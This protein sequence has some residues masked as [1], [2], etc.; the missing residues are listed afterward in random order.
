MAAGLGIGGS[1]AACRNA[2]AA[3]AA[4]ALKALAWL[5]VAAPRRAIDLAAGAWAGL[6]GARRRLGHV[7]RVRLDLFGASRAGVGVPGAPG[8]SASIVGAPTEEAR[9]AIAHLYLDGEWA[10]AP[11]DVQLAVGPAAFAAEIERQ[12]GYR[13]HILGVS[14][15]RGAGADAGEECQIT[16]SGGHSAT[17]RSPRAPGGRSLGRDL[18]FEAVFSPAP[19][20]PA[21]EGRR[22][23][24]LAILA[25]NPPGK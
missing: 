2:S 8:I 12:G 6:R 19:G 7:A 11:E 13:Y 22:A 23:E 21:R 25:R 1:Q 24:L 4:Y 3:A 5:A 18:S 14:A 20:G 15:A 16:V 10:V 17:L 9:R